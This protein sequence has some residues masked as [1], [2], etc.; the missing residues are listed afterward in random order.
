MDIA[1]LRQLFDDDLAHAESEADLRSVRDKYLS[2]KNGLISAFMKA[3]RRRRPEKRPR[4]GSGRQ[5][6]QAAY[7]RRRSTE[8]LAAGGRARARPA[9]RSTSRCRDAR[10]SSAIVIR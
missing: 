2:R 5:R 10:R 9:T 1:S 6:T 7:R 4:A 3:S 8:R